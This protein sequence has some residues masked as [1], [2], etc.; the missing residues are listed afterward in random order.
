MSVI[1]SESC[2]TVTD[3]R[4]DSLVAYTP[5]ILVDPLHACNTTSILVILSTASIPL[6]YISCDNYLRPT[7]GCFSI[8]DFIATRSLEAVMHMSAKD[9]P[10]ISYFVQEY[11]LFLRIFQ[12]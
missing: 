4:S 1:L 8:G 7:I 11:S 10:F 9:L 2:S 5:A 12:Q 3:W 6:Q